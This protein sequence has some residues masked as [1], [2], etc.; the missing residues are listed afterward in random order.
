MTLLT[1]GPVTDKQ[2]KDDYINE[3]VLECIRKTNP[4]SGPKV[5]ID[6]TPF[7]FFFEEEELTPE[8]LIDLE[9]LG[10]S[11]E[12]EVDEY[13][14]EFGSDEEN[15]TLFWEDEIFSHK[16]KKKN[17]SYKRTTHKNKKEKFNP[18]RYVKYDED[19]EDLPNK[20]RY[21]SVVTFSYTLGQEFDIVK[22]KQKKLAY[23]KGRP[24]KYGDPL[25]H[26]G[27]N[28]QRYVAPVTHDPFQANLERALQESMATSGQPLACG[29]TARQVLDLSNRDLTPE[30]YELLLMLDTQVKPKTVEL[31]VLDGFK[32]ETVDEGSVGDVCTICLDEYEIGELTATIPTCQ[33]K[34]HE[35]C[36]HQWL[37]NSSINCP[38]DGL[39]VLP[40]QV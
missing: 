5:T 24:I 18:S 12:D 21:P 9:Y 38:L 4:T 26:T 13:E 20:R 15:E 40:N 22:K 16:M 28:T 36:I 23:D 29:L 7:L 8:E 31:S 2:Q 32:K 14:D 17:Y 1:L 6:I 19:E 39:P 37:T 27:G 30:D 33:H 11:T 25:P 35:T 34:F 3:T 10:C